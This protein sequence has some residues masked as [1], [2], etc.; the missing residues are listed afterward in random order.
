MAASRAAVRAGVRVSISTGM[1]AG[2]GGVP[3]VLGLG[4]L[5]T[6][7]DPGELSVE[8][9]GLALEGAHP[10]DLGESARGRAEVLGDLL[11]VQ[12]SCAHER[13]ERGPGCCVPLRQVVDVGV[14]LDGELVERPD[15]TC[16]SSPFDAALATRLVVGA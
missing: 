10:R 16:A 11:V 4:L 1:A 12:R 13:L 9:E 15:G 7:G 3:V 14:G 6:P 2:P 5:A 8:V